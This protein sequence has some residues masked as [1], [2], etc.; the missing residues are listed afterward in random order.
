LLRGRL[1]W[2]G[3][4]QVLVV[5]PIVSQRLRPIASAH[6]AEDLATVT[7][8]IES[9]QVTPVI[10]RVYRLSETAQAVAHCGRGHVRGKIVISVGETLSSN[11]ES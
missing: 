5:S 1:A 2:G 11:G 7:E 10:D 4:V 3:A 6:K 9:G 8:L